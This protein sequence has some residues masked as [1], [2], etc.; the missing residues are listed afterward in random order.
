MGITSS[1]EDGGSANLILRLG[2]SIQEALRPSK[3]QIMQAW[4]EEDAERSGHL[5]RTRVQRVVTR[6]LEAQLEAAS[7]AASRAKLQVAKEQANMEKAGRRERA[8][9]R[10]LPPGGAT[11][12]H[13][14]RCTALMLGCAAGPVMAGMM[15][16]YVDVPVTCL[17]AMLQD[18]ELL[19]QRVEALFRMHGVEVPDS[20]GVESK[21]RLEDF[22]RSYLGY[23]D[24]AASLL[25]D[26]CTVPRSEESL[27]ST[28][29]TCC[30]Q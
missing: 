9:M 14:D 19:Q 20:T 15:A 18:K 12:E 1:S 26:A 27:P 5:S 25:N 28:V 6:L 13:L 3:Q 16:G 30:L 2:T 7:A 11:Q 21:L 22:Q 8:E 4:E 23:F 10:S 24:R 29:S 17:T